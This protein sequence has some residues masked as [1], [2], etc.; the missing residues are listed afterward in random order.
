MNSNA[1]V[2]HW[3]VG[4]VYHGSVPVCSLV[5]V[6]GKWVAT[7]NGHEYPGDERLRKAAQNFLDLYDPGHT[8]SV[9]G[10]NDGPT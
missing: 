9:Y 7:R 4:K 5:D 8:V 1:Y 10:A 3:T 6:D 2:L